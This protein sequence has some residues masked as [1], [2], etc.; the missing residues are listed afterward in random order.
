MNRPRC[1][2]LDYIQFLVAAQT[3]YSNTE[4]A[5]VILD[6]K[7]NVQRMMPIPVCWNAIH[8]IV[9]VSGKKFKTALTAERG[10]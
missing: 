9:P 7:A 6:Q 8:P 3:V 10:C 1:D 5:A 2:D 4:A